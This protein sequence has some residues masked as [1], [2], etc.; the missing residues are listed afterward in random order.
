[1]EIEN[2][3]TTKD[4]RD[5][6]YPLSSDNNTLK[7]T[8]RAHSSRT[9][10]EDM[11]NAVKRQDRSLAQ[12]IIADKKRR[13][14]AEYNNKKVRVKKDS[15]GDIL[16]LFLLAIII[17]AL[18]FFGIKILGQ[19]KNNEEDSSR[20]QISTS[21]IPINK[22]VLLNVK[23]FTNNTA[24]TTAIISSLSE[25]KTA[26][27][28]ILHLLLIKEVEITNEETK[29]TK[30]VE[31]T[32]P[33]S[34]FFEIWENNTPKSLIRSFKK[35]DYFFGY[36]NN[37]TKMTPL[38]L[39]ELKDFD[40]TF[41]GMLKWEN[42]LCKDIQN[43]FTP[44]NKCPENKFKNAQLLNTDIRVLEIEPGKPV[45]LYGFLNN[46]NMLIITQST[47]VFKEIKSLFE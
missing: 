23:D 8:K 32:L 37:Q 5:T 3:N 14:E 33:V 39:F 4:P 43:I 46:D 18:V 10:Q 47:T 19:Q 38:L 26:N 31:V 20:E 11:A 36:Y 1:M 44:K 7:D 29:K 25:K 9:L 21:I 28:D 22:Q 12:I 41:A 27:K 40:Q 13:R 15:S 6:P 17:I 30:K 16:K 42:V 24:F 45:I 35:E 2:H 34:E